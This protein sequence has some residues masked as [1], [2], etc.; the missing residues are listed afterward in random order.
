VSA[1]AQKAFANLATLAPNGSPQLTAV[2]FDLADR[3]IRI[4]GTH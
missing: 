2:C 3:H 4:V 1:S